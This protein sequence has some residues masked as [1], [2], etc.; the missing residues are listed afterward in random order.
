MLKNWLVKTKQI[1]KGSEGFVNYCNYL[2][3]NNASSHHDTRIVVLNDAANNIIKESD[4]RKLD[5][6][7]RGAG[8][9]GVMNLATSF[10]ISLPNDIKQPTDEEW[11]KIALYAVKTLSKE[12]DIDYEKLKSLSHIVLH[13]EKPPKKNHVHLSVSNIIDLEHFKKMTQFKATHVVKQSVNRS[14]KAVLSVCNT[15]YTPIR[16]NVPKTPLWASRA[17]KAKK[18][19][20]IIK[21]AEKLIKILNKFHK[22]IKNDISKW[23][24]DFLNNYF[25]KAS[26]NAVIVADGI[27]DIELIDSKI[28]VDLDKLTDYVEKK[29]TSAPSVAKVSPKRKKRRRSTKKKLE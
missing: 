7:E 29:N 14:V 27:N 20:F 26:K 16:K 13:N 19:V 11:A 2:K 23:S 3:N 12:F 1:K 15:E 24:D 5:R 22:N 28:A 21:R 10:V 18:D 9:K 25:P 6:K 4:D 8:G 17:E